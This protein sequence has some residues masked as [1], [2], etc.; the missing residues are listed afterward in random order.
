[1]AFNWH[2]SI[3]WGR[4]GYWIAEDLV[5]DEMMVVYPSDLGRDEFTGITRGQWEAWWR[6]REVDPRTEMP[7]GTRFP[8]SRRARQLLAP[9]APAPRTKKEWYKLVRDKEETRLA[10]AVERVA[11][12][13]QTLRPSVWQKLIRVAFGDKPAGK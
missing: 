12:P 6:A 3:P 10:P 7:D 5:D 1:L 4:D 11:S 2:G 9:D 13:E 8:V